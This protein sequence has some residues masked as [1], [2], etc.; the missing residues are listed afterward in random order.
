MINIPFLFYIP[1]PCSHYILTFIFLTT[2]GH[3]HIHNPSWNAFTSKVTLDHVN[4]IRVTRQKVQFC[5][6]LRIRFTSAKQA[7]GRSSVTSDTDQGQRPSFLI[8]RK[9]YPYPALSLLLFLT[10]KSGIF[11]FLSILDSYPFIPFIPRGMNISDRC[12]QV[13]LKIPHQKTMP[14]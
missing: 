13:K 5:G 14:L 8:C 9:L 4:D 11:I 12:I 2:A 3:G 6:S 7:G 10:E 1:Y